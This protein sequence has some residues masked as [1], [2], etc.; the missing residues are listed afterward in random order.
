MQQPGRLLVLFIER[1]RDDFLWVWYRGGSDARHASTFIA[2]EKRAVRRAD[3][4][5][6]NWEEVSSGRFPSSRFL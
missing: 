3:R 4:N 6:T 5:E 1:P 2:R